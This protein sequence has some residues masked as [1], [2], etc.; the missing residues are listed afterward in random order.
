MRKIEVD[1]A[2]LL[3]E[4]EIQV[5]DALIRG[6]NLN[7]FAK[8]CGLASSTAHTYRHRVLTKLKMKSNAEL[9]RWAVQQ[10]QAA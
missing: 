5:M 1:V 8:A 3:S 6:E 2:M 10:E 9:I 4:R 7:E